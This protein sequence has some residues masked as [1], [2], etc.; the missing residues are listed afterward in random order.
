LNTCLYAD[1][2]SDNGIRS[3]GAAFIAAK[4]RRDRFVLDVFANRILA[5]YTEHDGRTITTKPDAVTC[6][7]E[8]EFT[9][10]KAKLFGR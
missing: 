2:Y 8:E 10:R 1:E 7:T 4:N 9:A 5:E 6:Q 3:S